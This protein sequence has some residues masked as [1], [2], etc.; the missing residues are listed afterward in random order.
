LE[1]IALRAETARLKRLLREEAEARQRDNELVA[2]ELNAARQRINEV[3][4]SLATVTTERDSARS[5]ANE[6]EAALQ[7]HLMQKET[8]LEVSDLTMQLGDLKKGSAKSSLE[9][10]A[11][12]A[13]TARLKRLLREEAEARQRDNELVA[14]ELNAAR[15]SAIELEQLEAPSHM[16]DP[17]LFLQVQEQLEI[18][19]KE[20]DQLALQLTEVRR[21]LLEIE[22]ARDQ[23]LR[24]NAELEDVERERDVMRACLGT[25]DEAERNLREYV[26]TQLGRVSLLEEEVAQMDRA[27]RYA[28][29]AY[30]TLHKELSTVVKE[31]ERYRT[32]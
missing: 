5:Y 30:R 2:A 20:R 13:E 7:E 11:L 29:E 24:Q 6:V 27:R 15:Q 3:E 28:E 18:T 32:F 16:I 17:P 4:A 1:L 10:I 22:K 31:E 26:S 21:Q 19:E 23:L 25:L 8:G 12:R 14:A 9:L